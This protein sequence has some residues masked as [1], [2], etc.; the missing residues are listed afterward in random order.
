M[1]LVKWRS[2][3]HFPTIHSNA[4]ERGDMG[5]L[6][7]ALKLTIDR[8]QTGY[9]ATKLHILLAGP[10]PSELTTR[11][12][13]THLSI[14]REQ[15]RYEANTRPVDDPFYCALTERVSALESEYE[16]RSESSH[17]SPSP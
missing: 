3:V 5:V 14:A 4:G 12:L 13:V 8:L 10:D 16:Q 6:L 17:Q 7:T 15:L 11:E 1:V 9:R 2:V